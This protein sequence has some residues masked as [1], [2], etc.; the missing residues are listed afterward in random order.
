MS[1]PPSPS[2]SIVC[3]KKNTHTFREREENEDVRAVTTTEKCIVHLSW[4]ARWA[5]AN[6][7]VVIVANGDADGVRYYCGHFQSNI[8]FYDA[9][10]AARLWRITFVFTVHL[11]AISCAFCSF[12]ALFYSIPLDFLLKCIQVQ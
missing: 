6:Y 12:S 5:A 9:I 10:V 11:I 8:S 4:G 7:N 3:K 2:C 1:L